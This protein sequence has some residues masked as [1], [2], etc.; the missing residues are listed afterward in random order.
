MP[1][2]G[3]SMVIRGDRFDRFEILSGRCAGSSLLSIRRWGIGV[4]G[5]G[6]R[7]GQAARDYG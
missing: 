6:D 3:E 5:W 1:G 2:N 4:R 7:V